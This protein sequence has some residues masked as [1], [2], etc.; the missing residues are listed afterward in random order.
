MTTAATSPITMTDFSMAKNPTITEHDF[1]FPR[2]PFE[3]TGGAEEIKHE[4]SPEDL[5]MR[6]LNLDMTD[7]AAARHD[8]LKTSLFP[9][10]EDGMS[11]SDA[12]IGEL[13]T[14]D[15]LAMQI[16][17]FF[18]KTKQSLPR[19]E[20]MENFTWRM[21]HVN[22]RKWRKQ[23]DQHDERTPVHGESGQPPI[24]TSSTATALVVDTSSSARHT[25]HPSSSTAGTTNAPS[26]IAQLRKATDQNA[27]QSEPMNLDDF[28]YPDHVAPSA[29]FASSLT[30]GKQ[31]TEKSATRATAGAIP[32]KSRKASGQHFV[33]QSVPVPPHQ[34]TQDEFGYV[35]RHHRKTSVDERRVSASLFHMPPSSPGDTSLPNESLRLVYYR[36]HLLFHFH[37]TRL[38]L[39]TSY[40]LDSLTNNLS[41]SKP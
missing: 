34:R 31:E 5:R 11:G 20:R 13:Q 26:G 19:Q 36:L 24:S 4:G 28:I 32:I 18:S 7:A 23:R 29:G 21:M 35:A 16:W 38:R 14:Q 39:S 1:R 9:H 27:S 41:G 2:R 37:H 22:L 8:F 30:S 3:S 33:P 40:M 17:R 12:T 10:L 25:S 15:P 6:E